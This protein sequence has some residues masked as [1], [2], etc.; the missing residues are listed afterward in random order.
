MNRH[1]QS[2]GLRLEVEGIWTRRLAYGWQSC[3]L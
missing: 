3:L 1:L 2:A